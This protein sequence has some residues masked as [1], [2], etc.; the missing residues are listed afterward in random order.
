MPRSFISFADSGT[1]FLGDETGKVISAEPFAQVNWARR[2]DLAT[3]ALDRLA[4]KARATGKL[5]DGWD[6]PFIQGS[7]IGVGVG[8]QQPSGS[9]Q[10]VS[11]VD[12]ISEGWEFELTAQPV[13]NWNIT[14]NYSKTEATKTYFVS[15]QPLSFAEGNALSPGTTA[16]CL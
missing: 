9:Q 13:K 14:V 5:Y 1:L 11:T 2:I 12:N 8:G 15:G 7:T 4:A 3:D 16:S 6:T 10:P